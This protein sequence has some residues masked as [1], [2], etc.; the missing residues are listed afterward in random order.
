MNLRWFALMLPLLTGCG[1]EIE[2]KGDGWIDV[3]NAGGSASVKEVV[4]PSGTRC[5]VLIG[6]TK[7]AIACDWK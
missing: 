4:M 1:R 3:A 6:Y 7:G 5:V 2:H